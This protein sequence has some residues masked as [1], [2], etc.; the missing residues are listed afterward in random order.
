MDQPY[1]PCFNYE[2]VSDTHLGIGARIYAD[3]HSVERPGHLALSEGSALS[4]ADEANGAP[5]Q[6]YDRSGSGFVLRPGGYQAAQMGG[7]RM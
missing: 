6:A 2:I 1:M 7:C 5:P 3:F 4:M